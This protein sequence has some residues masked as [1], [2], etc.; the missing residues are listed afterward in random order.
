MA[1]GKGLLEEV[2]FI[3]S[4]TGC[5]GFILAP[6]QSRAGSR[7]AWGQLVVPGRDG[8]VASG[9][10]GGELSGGVFQTRGW[11]DCCGLGEDRRG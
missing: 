2:A 9:V 11:Q 8:V 7:E 10:R 6:L 3:R 1:E 5:G 4:P